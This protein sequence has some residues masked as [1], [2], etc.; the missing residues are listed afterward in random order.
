MRNQTDLLKL[1]QNLQFQVDALES[2]LDMQSCTLAALWNA[3]RSSGGEQLLLQIQRD[4]RE[5]Y[6]TMELEHL[7]SL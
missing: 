4:A 7:I 2:R 1:A 5:L 3:V 6:Q